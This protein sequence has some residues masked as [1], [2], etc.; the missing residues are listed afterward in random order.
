MC[1]NI[2]IIAYKKSFVFRDKTICDLPDIVKSQVL[3]LNCFVLNISTLNLEFGIKKTY[4]KCSIKTGNEHLDHSSI[5]I[6]MTVYILYF[7]LIMYLDKISRF[8]FFLCFVPFFYY[9]FCMVL[10]PFI[11]FS[12]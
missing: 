1:L 7:F 8:I 4:L 12:I 9:Y 5:V 3:M 2:V 10:F 6:L 11:C